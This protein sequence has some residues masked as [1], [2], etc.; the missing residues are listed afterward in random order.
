MRVICLGVEHALSA[1]KGPDYEHCER[2]PLRTLR[3]RL[4]LF[5]KSLQVRISC[6]SGTEDEI[7]GFANGFL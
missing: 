7:V 1:F 5:E 3:S 6:G 4:S 2:L